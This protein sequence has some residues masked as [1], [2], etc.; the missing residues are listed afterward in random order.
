MPHFL[1]IKIAA[2][3][4][5]LCL[6]SATVAHAGTSIAG[7]SNFKISVKTSVS[8]S[9]P[10]KGAT[11]KGNLTIKYTAEI[12]GI[13]LPATAHIISSFPLGPFAKPKV[14]SDNCLGAA[15][16]R[17]GYDSYLKKNAW[18]VTGDQKFWGKTTLFVK[19]KA[20]VDAVSSGYF[21]GGTGTGH[22]LDANA[23]DYVKSHK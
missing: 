17:N 3:T 19:G 7:D 8:D 1:L 16:Y 10:K 23:R 22:L 15:N 14:T 5:G 11:M 13:P 12:L 20:K 4:A 2:A 18:I 6:V 9:T 21:H